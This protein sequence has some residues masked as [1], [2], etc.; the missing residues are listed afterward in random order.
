MKT[1]LLAT[2][3]LTSIGTI[4]MADAIC[5]SISSEPGIYIVHPDLNDTYHMRKLKGSNSF[6]YQ[7][8]LKLYL[9]PN[10]PQN[11]VETT[12]HVRVQ[13]KTSAL[14]KQF[15]T[16]VNRN[17]VV[18]KCKQVDDYYGSDFDFKQD[19]TPI[20]YG[21]HDDHVGPNRKTKYV[22]G[23]TEWHFKWKDKRGE[24]ESGC[25]NTQDHVAVIEDTR[26]GHAKLTANIDSVAVFKKAAA[27][28]PPRYAYNTI[29]SVLV[30]RRA[31]A[32]DCF[33]VGIK[34]TPGEVPSKTV[35]KYWHLPETTATSLVITWK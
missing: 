21:D 27:E 15:V 14:A 5:D 16:Y 22:K 11:G 8:G 26:G 31:D 13:N 20:G 4:T 1:I 24:G 12:W 29:A 9:V 23:L 17:K 34:N 33:T 6:R 25:E 10:V 2:A 18:S 32:Y 3:M 19:G 7:K 30:H 35:V 28:N